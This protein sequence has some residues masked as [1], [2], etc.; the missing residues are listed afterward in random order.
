M[1]RLLAASGHRRPA[2]RAGTSDEVDNC[3]GASRRFN[4]VNE[5]KGK[6]VRIP[7]VGVPLGVP[8]LVVSALGGCVEVCA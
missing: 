7:R 1:K 3:P 2:G 4:L 5:K 8:A 6:S